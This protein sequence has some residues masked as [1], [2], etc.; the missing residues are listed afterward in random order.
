MTNLS[1]LL[2]AA[3]VLTL[4]SGGVPAFAQATTGTTAAPAASTTAP[5]KKGTHKAT[6]KT[7]TKKSTKTPA[8]PS[9]PAGE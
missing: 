7:H 1:R 6:K 4:V 8:E 9:G 2:M 5:A 3:S